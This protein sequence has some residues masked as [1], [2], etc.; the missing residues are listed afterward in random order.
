MSRYLFVTVEGG[1]N[2][3]PILG[4]ARRMRAHGHDVRVLGDPALGH[5]ARALDL[6]FAPFVHAPHHNMRNRD[7]DRVRDWTIRNP[8]RHLKV[9]LD[10]V[11]FDPALAYARDTLA[12][13]EEFA[14]DALALDYL[15]VGASIGAEKARL[16]YALLMHTPYALPAPGL[17]PLGTGLL[18]GKT[19]LGR[20]RD[21][22]LGWASK[23]WIDRIGRTKINATR[24]ALSLPPLAHLTDLPHKADQILV[25]TARG[26]DYASRVTLP[27]NVRY[28]GPG[29]DD[30]AWTEPYQLPLDGDDMP[31]VVVGLGSTF[32]NQLATTTN[33]IDALGSL[34][35]RGLVTLGKVFEPQMLRAPANVALVRSAPH[36]A[37]FPQAR[38]VICH[39]GHGTV[40]KALSYGLPV[41][42]LPF[43][44]DQH[45][46]AARVEACGA[47]LRLRANASP[48]KIRRAVERLLVDPSFRA[49][50]ARLAEEIAE[51]GRSDP[52]V[53]A[54][55][56]LPRGHAKIRACEQLS[57]H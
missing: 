16:P 54:L 25:M 38:V 34:P 44:R 57:L 12:Q 30:P 2:V 32:Q 52:A 15:V 56:G 1:G 43:G 3:P 31:L 6:D 40:L 4:L 9:M 18:P 14:P 27:D 11:A 24:A 53:T 8:L 35:V 5:D 46:N 39:G 45:D 22:L 19:F 41:L 47:G 13:I 21:R 55:E 51:D 50:A 29:L 23:L 28:V 48:A 10:H 26:F 36:H 42:C 37:V 33:V 7:N 20:Q 17:P 49:N